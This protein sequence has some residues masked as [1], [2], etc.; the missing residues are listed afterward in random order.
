[1]TTENVG[2]CMRA[3]YLLRD[4]GQDVV[5]ARTVIARQYGGIADLELADVPRP[6]LHFG[7]HANRGP[8]A[9]A[10]FE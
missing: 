3:V 9:S 1:M 10:H 4:P 2:A 7:E 8:L 6:V 5:M